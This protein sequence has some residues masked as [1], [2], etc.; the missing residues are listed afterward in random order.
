MIWL[1]TRRHDPENYQCY[2]HL[3]KVLLKAKQGDLVIA[4]YRP[5][6]ELEFEDAQM[7]Y[8]RDYRKMKD[9]IPADTPKLGYVLDRIHESEFIEPVKFYPVRISRMG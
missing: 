3:M 4:C 1:N 5:D 2:Y 7:Y 8:D 6:L 9:G